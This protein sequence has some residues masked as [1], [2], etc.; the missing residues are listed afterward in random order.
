MQVPIPVISSQKLNGVGWDGS[1][2]GGFEDLKGIF[3]SNLDVTAWSANRLDF[4]GLG[5]DS[6]AYHDWW[7]GA[8]VLQPPLLQPYSFPS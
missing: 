3:T 7:N 1:A 6:A 4:F 8:A 2:W 5:T